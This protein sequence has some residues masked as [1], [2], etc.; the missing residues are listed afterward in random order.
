[1]ILNTKKPQLV[2]VWGGFVLFF[3]KEMILYIANCPFWEES[4]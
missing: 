3:F 1:M 4:G 2:I